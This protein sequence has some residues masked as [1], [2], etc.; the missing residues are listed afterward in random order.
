MGHLLP[1]LTGCPAHRVLHAVVLGDVAPAAAAALRA[2]QLLQPFIAEH[3][4]R[5]GLNHEQGPLVVHAALPQFL[6][7]EEM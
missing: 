6:R 1:E 5:I 3:Q 2:E 7:L 4:H